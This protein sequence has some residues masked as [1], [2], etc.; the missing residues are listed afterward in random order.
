MKKPIIVTDEI[1]GHGIEFKITELSRDDVKIELMPDS[2]REGIMDMIVCNEREG[3]F[4]TED[5]FEIDGEDVDVEIK[6]TWR[7]L[8]LTMEPLQIQS[9]TGDTIEIYLSPDKYPA[10]Y[11]RKKQELTEKSGMT[12][13]EAENF[14]LTTPFILEIFYDIDRGLFGLESEFIECN[15]VF[16][17]HT[18]NLIPNEEKEEQKKDTAQ[19]IDKITCNLSD[20][21]DQ[22]KDIN[23]NGTLS[24]EGEEVMEEAINYLED[25]LTEIHKFTDPD[26]KKGLFEEQ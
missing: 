4:D 21:L 5:I 9:E 15:N 2:I 6:G 1:C 22:L 12:E 11:A 3:T 16:N 13:S 17:P 25:C 18:G 8:Q 20:T 26:D 7:I 24:M 19:E 23:V 14:L 10:A